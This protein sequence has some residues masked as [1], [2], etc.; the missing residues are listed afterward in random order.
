MERKEGTMWERAQ[1]EEWEEFRIS[2]GEGHEIWPDDKENEWKS[3]TER[4]GNVGDICRTRQR[5]GIR[6]KMPRNHWDDLSYDSQ[7]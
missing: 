7:H 2:D 4:C 5:P 1:G 3:E 6:K